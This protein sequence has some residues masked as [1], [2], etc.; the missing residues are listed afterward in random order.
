MPLL[1][2]T[3]VMTVI[4]SINGTLQLFDESVNLTS[5]GPANT[6]ITMSHYI[7]NSS[8]GQGTANFGYATAMSFFVLLLV[9]ILSFISMKAG[10]KQAVLALFICSLAGFGFELYHDKAKDRLFGILL[11]A[12][13]VPQV[14]TMIPL[15]RMI[16]K[17]K[18]LNTVWAFILPSI[19]TPFLMQKALRVPS[20]KRIFDHTGAVHSYMQLY[21]I[22]FII[23]YYFNK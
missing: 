6:T 14:A 11:L 17:M 21:F 1:K 13:M 18:L 7:Y 10:D 19:S 12:M 5:G 8:F 2:P 16:S 23:S 9:A 4:M 22:I 3:I 15:F 20:N